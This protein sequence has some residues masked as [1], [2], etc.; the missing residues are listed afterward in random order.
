[1]RFATLSKQNKKKFRFED[2]QYIRTYFE[3]LGFNEIVKA[4]NNQLDKPL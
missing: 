1:M 3:K 2:L 4:I